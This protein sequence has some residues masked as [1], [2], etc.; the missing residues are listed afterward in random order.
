MLFDFFGLLLQTFRFLAGRLHLL[1]LLFQLGQDIFKVFVAFI[2]QVVRF[3]QN[4]LRQTQ[5]P[6]NSKGVGL[7]RNT[8]QKTIGGA[9]GV[10]VKL[11]GSVDDTLCPHGVEFQFG[12][13]GGCHHSA[14]HLSAEFDDG[15]GQRCT[16]RRVGTGS[17]LIKQHQRPVIALVHHIHNGAHMAGERGQALG[18]GLLISDIRQ[19]QVEG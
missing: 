7:S 14:A 13:V 18:N 16:F 12:I 1:P 2:N 8:D 11:A 5:F 6:G 9:Q 19:N 15:C 4:F 17:Q 3:F 10:Y